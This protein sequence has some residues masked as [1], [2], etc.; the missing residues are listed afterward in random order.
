MGFGCFDH[1]LQEAFRVMVLAFTTLA[2]AEG[3]LQQMQEGSAD[4]FVR[5][6]GHLWGHRLAR[7]AGFGKVDKDGRIPNMAIYK[8]S[9]VSKQ[10]GISS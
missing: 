5:G 6:R 10:I 7:K 4:F 3:H 1:L 9:K 2:V 8:N